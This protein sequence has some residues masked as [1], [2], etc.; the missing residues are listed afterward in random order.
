MLK[1]LIADDEQIERIALQQIIEHSIA[2]VEVVGLAEHGRRAC[3]LAEEL[4]PDLVL[5]DIRMPGMDGLEAVRII[6]EAQ[7]DIKFVI[8]SAFDAFEYAQQAIRYNVSDYLL[9]PSKASD[10]VEK[11]EAV[12]NEIRL[13]KKDKEKISEDLDTIQKVMPIVETDLVAQLLL[14]HVHE[15]HTDEMMRIL[16][17]EPS[18][19]AY[20]MLVYIT[21]QTSSNHQPS[22]EI[23]YSNIKRKLHQYGKGWVGAMSGH[24]IP[25]IIFADSD[26]SYRSQAALII[27]KLILMEHQYDVKIFIGVGGLKETLDD[28]R[29]SYHE[30]ILASA[31]PSLPSKHYFYEALSSQE[32]Q[33]SMRMIDMEKSILE[34]FRKGNRE[35]LVH[36]LRQM[37]DNME[38]AYCTI[39]EAQHRVLE[40][41]F[42]TCR[43]F[44]ETGVELEKPQLSLQAANYQQLEIETVNVFD[45]MLATYR[46]TKEQINPDVFQSLK[47][48]IINHAHENVSLE[49]IA[50]HVNRSPYYVSKCFKE[51]FGMNYI[52]FLTQCRIEKA[53]TLMTNRELSLKEICYEVGYNDPNYFSR[54]FKRVCGLS[55]TEYR[56]EYVT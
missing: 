40:L 23:I 2:H 25:Y 14:D 8:V 42:M 20:V 33:E 41:L 26:Q 38:C 32:G 54:V 6:S 34:D 36:K 30:A 31:N 22:L 37:I 46:D 47:Q 51:Q 9:K 56:K 10:I 44:L 35:A 55:P 1:I 13:E 12:L 49:M 27:R 50:E 21:P 29:Q 11:L 7:P 52:D 39:V 28:I 15:V 3:E 5:M 19:A 48:Y 4:R 24:Q 43:I 45:K 18:R 17:I 53:K 16:H